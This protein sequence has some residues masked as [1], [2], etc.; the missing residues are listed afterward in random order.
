MMGVDPIEKKP[1]FHFHPG[2]TSLS[3]ST[4]G[5][6]FRC[7]FCQ[8]YDI[9]QKPFGM[10]RVEPQ[11][12]AEEAARRG[13]RSVSYTYNEP[14]VFFE[15]AVDTAKESLKRGVLNTFVTNGYMT[16]EAVEYAAPYIQ[17]MT[18]GIKGSLNREF[19]A[20]L[21]AVPNPEAIQEALLEMKRR[22]I[23]IE[24]TDLL[25]TKYGDNLDDVRR[26]ARWVHDNLGPNTPLHFTRFHPDW[27]LTDVPPTPIEHL[28]R[29][30]TVAKEEE[31]KYVY[32]G[33][34]AGHSLENTY[35]PE[36]N[37]LL[38]KRWGFHIEE[39]R[40]KDKRCSQCG[41]EIFYLDHSEKT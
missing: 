21:M 22:G 27:R 38:I 40:I 2:S 30:Y 15:Y 14:T 11:V 37:D 19:S 4:V 12:I 33:N 35:C 13:C 32:L 7:K 3:I 28:E 6:T 26:L 10:N 29:A 24:I 17:A 1:F 23:H 9:S 18:V 25:V 16:P 36:C 20:R 41:A 34:V 39:W 8:N 31:M 5:C